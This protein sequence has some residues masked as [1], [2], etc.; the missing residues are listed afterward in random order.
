MRLYYYFG[1]GIKSLKRNALHESFSALV[2]AERERSNHF[3]SLKKMFGLMGFW[4]S[5]FLSSADIITVF[6]G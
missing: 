1:E 6:N 2:S 5:L 3:D 4:G